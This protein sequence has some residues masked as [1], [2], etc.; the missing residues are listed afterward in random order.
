MTKSM[1]VM[2]L[3]CLSCLWE[4]SA[5]AQDEQPS[6][7]KPKASNTDCVP[8]CRKG[9]LCIDGVCVSACN[10][11]CPDGKLCLNNDCVN[12][13]NAPV[14]A[15]TPQVA[16]ETT[17][18]EPQRVGFVGSVMPGISLCVKRGSST[19]SNIDPGF[20]ISGSFGYRFLPYIGVS[21]DIFLGMYSIRGANFAGLL[22]LVA[23]PK[24]Y[25]PINNVDFSVGLGLGVAQLMVDD[26][27]ISVSQTG[28]GLSVTAGIEA[29]IGRLI[30][31]G[32]GFRTNFNFG[33]TVCSEGHCL[34]VDSNN[35]AANLMLG[36]ILTW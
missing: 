32:I 30:G 20:G 2:C 19:C 28:F 16:P 6:I 27:S 33:G 9:F 18:V 3:A 29:R 14:V 21:G 11:P 5:L 34:G 26:S 17:T 23:G 22:G 7:P 35:N 12:E 24:F 4:L 10:P 8:A 31:L 1:L 15:P 13:Q 25:L 36:C